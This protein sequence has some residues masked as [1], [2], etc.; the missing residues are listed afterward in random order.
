MT[1]NK[2]LP[3]NRIAKLRKEKNLSQAQ[4]AKGTGLTRQAISLYEIGKREPKLE[5]WLKLANFFN[6]PVSYLQGISN[7]RTTNLMDKSLKDSLANRA[8]N[9]FMNIVNS[10]IDDNPIHT[11]S[12]LVDAYHG[13]KKPGEK[14]SPQKS[15]VLYRDYLIG[16][17]ITDSKKIIGF[18]DVFESLYHAFLFGYGNG[19]D[20]EKEFYE[21]ILKMVKDHQSSKRD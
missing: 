19:N 11:Y 1:G 8:N 6:V 7:I 16:Q 5:T 17:H 10:S 3:Q 12:R 13:R 14:L 18:V 9:D 15:A 20:A 21:R 4:L 2:K